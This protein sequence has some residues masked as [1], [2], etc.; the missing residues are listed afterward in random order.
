MAVDQLYIGK[1]I[2][3]VCLNVPGMNRA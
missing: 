3:P 2:W 1:A